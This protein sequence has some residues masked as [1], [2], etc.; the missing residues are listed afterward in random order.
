MKMPDPTLMNPFEDH[1]IAHTF[2][3]ELDGFQVYRLENTPQI[4][5]VLSGCAWM[6]SDGRDIFIPRGEDVFLATTAEASLISSP[7]ARPLVFEVIPMG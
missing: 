7:N 4:V 3:I 5:R 1:L 2:I 6:T